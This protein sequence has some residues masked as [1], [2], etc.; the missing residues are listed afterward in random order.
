MSRSLP[1]GGS[2]CSNADVYKELGDISGSIIAFCVS[3]T[4][5]LGFSFVIY[6]RVI[7]C[8]S[9]F[10]MSGKTG[11]SCPLGVLVS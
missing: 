7:C 1:L 10:F 5:L 11:S 3:F 8:S 4:V 6:S 9:H 2:V